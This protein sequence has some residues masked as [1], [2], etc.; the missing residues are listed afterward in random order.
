MKHYGLIGY[1][2]THSFSK[3][4]FSGKFERE[5][6][7]DCVYENYPL[8]AID[9]FPALLQSEKTL[10]GLNVTIPY[11]ESVMQYLHE[12]DDTAR[13]I[14]A[15]NTIRIAGGRMKGYNTDVYGF[16]HSITPMLEPQHHHALILG[17]GGSSK[18]V[19][20]SF[21]KMGI[22]YQF[23]SRNPAHPG[24]ISYAEAGNQISRSKIIVNT[25]PAGMYPNVDAAPD[26]PYEKI[27]PAHILFDLVYNPEETLFL[28][29]G[30]LQQANIKNGLEMLQLQAEKSWQIWNT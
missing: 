9:E 24:E 25:T 19:A 28:Q 7:A 1:P 23:V 8:S 3:K 26:I 22:S 2:L 14:G 15:V 13:E 5:H 20:W 21:R 6:I 17:T 18:A 29:R 16:M 27:T 30:K 12:L 10:V 4:Y 11:K